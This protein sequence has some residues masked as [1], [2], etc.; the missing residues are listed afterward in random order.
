[1]WLGGRLN[2]NRTVIFEE[3]YKLRLR[4]FEPARWLKHPAKNKINDLSED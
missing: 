2:N 3:M 1:M 4:G